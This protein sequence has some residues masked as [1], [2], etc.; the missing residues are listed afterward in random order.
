MRKRKSPAEGKERVERL[1]G[2]KR[3]ISEGLVA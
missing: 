1:E 3:V 2:V